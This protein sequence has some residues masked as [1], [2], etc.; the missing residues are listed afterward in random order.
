MERAPRRR[1]AA[2]EPQGNRNEAFPGKAS[3]H[4]CSFPSE[5]RRAHDAG[6]SVAV[7]YACPGVTLSLLQ[8]CRTL[9][10]GMVVK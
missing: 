2:R 8:P 3:K 6:R 9:V 7:Y 10:T 4:L 1:R 5:P